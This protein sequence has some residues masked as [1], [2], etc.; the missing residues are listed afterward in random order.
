MQAEGMLKTFVDVAFNE[1]I[2]RLSERNQTEE[3]RIKTYTTHFRRFEYAI[4]V[5]F[6]CRDLD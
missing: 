5:T 2:R 4:H 1:V 3:S 6:I